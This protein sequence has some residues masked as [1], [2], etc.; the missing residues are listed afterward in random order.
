M[1]ERTGQQRFGLIG[2]ISNEMKSR[3]AKSHI[4][5]NHPFE[6]LSL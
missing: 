6:L 2:Y 4:R 3:D 5:R 1:G